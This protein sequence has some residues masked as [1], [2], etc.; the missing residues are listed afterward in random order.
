MKRDGLLS[1]R[2]HRKPLKAGA[3]IIGVVG[4]GA[5]LFV[6]GAGESIGNKLTDG[7]TRVF[8]E[9]PTLADLKINRRVDSTGMP[10]GAQA[11]YLV[12]YGSTLPK[13]TYGGYCSEAQHKFY[14]IG[15]MTVGLLQITLSNDY[16]G[17]RSSQMQVASIRAIVVRSR[18]ARKG[19]VVECGNSGGDTPIFGVVAAENNSFVKVSEGA[20]KDSRKGNPL[21][22]VLEK[23]EPQ[24]VNLIIT[25]TE[26]DVEV[27]LRADVIIRGRKYEVNLLYE[28]IE[29]ASESVSSPIRAS[30]RGVVKPADA[31]HFSCKT[32][33]GE[34]LCRDGRVF[35]EDR[36][37]EVLKDR[38][39]RMQ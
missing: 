33:D 31:S 12:P 3:A 7:V 13:I 34:D 9:G 11:N 15:K 23:G 22:F 39:A 16:E 27:T 8:D 25:P 6:T 5:G 18:P 20:S 26:K 14:K 32:T 38:Q 30:P 21:S 24:V 36:E 29:V 37:I 28:P 17:A 4:V 19:V 1:E 2:K 10:T 35:T